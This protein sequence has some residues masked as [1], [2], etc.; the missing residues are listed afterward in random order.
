[1]IF[2]NVSSK[3]WWHYWWWIVYPCFF[4]DS[5]V[6]VF[7]FSFILRVLKFPPGL[8]KW[9][10]FFFILLSTHWM[11]L[12]WRLCF[13]S[14]EIFFYCVLFPVP[15]VSSIISTH[16][17]LWGLDFLSLFLLLCLMLFLLPCKKIFLLEEYLISSAL[18]TLFFTSPVESCFCFWGFFF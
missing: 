4:V 11:L 6:F 13:L 8:L 15:L 16:Y 9:H 1:M 14:S 12:F 10:V 17:N 18:F 3:A 5:L 2:K 7:I